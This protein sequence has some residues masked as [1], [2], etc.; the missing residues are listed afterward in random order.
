[1]FLEFWVLLGLPR[2]LGPHGVLGSPRVLG[3][4]KVLGP[5]RVL[6]P[7]RVLDPD[8]SWVLTGCCVHL[9][10]WVLGPLRVLGLV[11]SVCFVFSVFLSLDQNL[12][13]T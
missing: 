11:F 5:P 6:G 13:K 4:H 12:M 7:S 2:V 8:G 10:S 3:P 1:M 9:G